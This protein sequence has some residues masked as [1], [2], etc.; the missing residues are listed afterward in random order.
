MNRDDY[1]TL[2]SFPSISSHPAHKK[3]VEACADWIFHYLKKHAVPVEKWTSE[4]PPV[5]FSSLMA[6]PSKPTLLLYGHYDVQPVEPLDE[7]ISPPFTPT[8]RNGEIYARGAQDNKGQLFY[9][10]Q[11]LIQLKN[12][13]INIKLLVEGEEEIGSPHLPFILKTHQEKLKADYL[14]IVDVGMFDKKTPAIT[15]GA[16]GII[17]FTVEFEGTKGDL[18]S[19]THGGV[20]Y[21]PLRALVECLSKLHDPLT[22]RVQVPGFYDDVHEERMPNLPFDEHAYLLTF[23]APPTG[24]E[25]GYTPAERAGLRPTLEINGISGGYAGTGFKTVIPAKATAKLSCRLV[26]HQN[27]QDIAEKVA[28]YLTTLA[29]PGI[30]IHVDIHSGGGEAVRANPHSPLVKAFTSAYQEI[31][32]TPPVHLYEGGSIPITAT[33]AKLTGA[34]PLL[35]GLGLNDDNIHAPNEHFSSDRIE[36]GTQS[37][38]LAIQYLA[39]FP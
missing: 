34:E 35:V 13:P 4:A 26:P 19:G 8:E 18:H 30:K 11:A 21:N 33:L 38:L 9:T 32:G 28:T 25:K 24:G 15:L 3:D 36:K 10:L 20:V 37:L 6:D 39:T 2:L 5:I 1:Y 17:T 23:G 14:A 29:P 31:F 16:R 22:G 27:P 12:P 7:W